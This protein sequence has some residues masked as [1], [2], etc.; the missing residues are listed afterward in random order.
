MFLDITHRRLCLKRRPVY[1]SKHNVSEISPYLLR[2]GLA[3]AI[4]PNWVGLYLKTET[5]YTVPNV[6]FPNK[7]DDG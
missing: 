7:E 6:V 4:W 5:E 2:S 1:I 3:L